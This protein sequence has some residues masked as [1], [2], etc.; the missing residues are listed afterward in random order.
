MFAVLIA[1][2]D[3]V[4]KFFVRNMPEGQ[5]FFSAP[6][7][8]ELRHVT[9]TGAAFSLLASR[10][11]VIMFISVLLTVLLCLYLAH[12]KSLSGAACTAISGLI[13]GG[14]GNLLDRV[15]WGGVT[16]Y[17]NLIFIRFPIFNFADI[18]VTL[19]VAALILLLLF[20]RKTEKT[21][22]FHG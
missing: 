13:G 5:T 9:N 14:I 3:Q 11:S 1:A 2:I 7:F 8:F 12:E 15:F 20:E 4:I 10:Q 6:P 18:C 19:S 22:E 17:I 16:D 21:E